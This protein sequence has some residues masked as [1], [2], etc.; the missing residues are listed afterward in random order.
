MTILAAVALVASVTTTSDEPAVLAAVQRFFD[1]M[2]S[3]DVEGAKEIL[4]PEGRLFSVRTVDGQPVVRSSTFQEYLDGLKNAQ[5]DWLERMWD[6]EV[7]IQGEIAMV[8][9]PYDF[10]R[11]GAFSHCGIDAFNLMKI[12]GVWKITGGSYTVERSGCAPSPLGP[13]KR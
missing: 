6:P 5:E 2:A 11:N 7:R 8:W 9:T 10:H 1:T 4:V 13:P 12:D 3:K